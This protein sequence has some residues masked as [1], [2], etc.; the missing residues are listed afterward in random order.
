MKLDQP[1]SGAHVS[2]QSASD[3]LIDSRDYGFRVDHRP[4]VDLPPPMPNQEIERNDTP[5]EANALT[6][7]DFVLGRLDSRI[8]QDWFVTEAD[9]TGPVRLALD[10]KSANRWLD[11]LMVD[12]FQDTSP[13]QLAL[14]LKL[15]RFARQVVWVGDIKQSIYGFRGSDPT[16]M[17][18]VVQRVTA[19]G[20][21]PEILPRSWRSTPALVAYVNNLFVPA[22]ADSLK[23][24]QVELQPAR[25]AFT[26]EPAVELWRLAGGKKSER[27]QAL[28]S[29][30]AGMMAGG[31][32]VVDKDSKQ[33]RAA[34]Y[35]D[36]P[37]SYAHPPAFRQQAL[38]QAQTKGEARPEPGLVLP[39]TLVVTPATPLPVGENWQLLVRSVTT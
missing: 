12:E 31:R 3:W 17:A 9:R 13:I 36:L 30:I 8:D 16:L 33:E 28:A 24:Q 22:F 37:R 26:S 27:A 34:T 14:F 7:G 20:N 5:A 29:A 10:L 39:G 35:S 21:E 11:L 6:M 2:I 4:L 18:A 1:V 15:A 38:N 19:D 32:T 23:P 25:D